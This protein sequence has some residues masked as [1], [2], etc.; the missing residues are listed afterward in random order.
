MKDD[1]LHTQEGDQRP[2]YCTIS[3]LVIPKIYEIFKG[4]SYK[5][6]QKLFEAQVIDVTFCMHMLQIWCLNHAAML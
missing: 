6:Y 2:L 4:L 3:G 5:S 1:F